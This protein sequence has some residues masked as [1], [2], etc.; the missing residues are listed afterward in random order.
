MTDPVRERPKETPRE[1]GSKFPHS[2]LDGSIMGSK[3]GSCAFPSPKANIKYMQLQQ[4]QL[5]NSNNISVTTDTA[6]AV[7]ELGKI[8]QSIHLRMVA[9]GYK[10]SDSDIIKINEN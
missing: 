1:N 9:S 7:L 3:R 4:E 2:A 5:N 6:L 8:L 10:I